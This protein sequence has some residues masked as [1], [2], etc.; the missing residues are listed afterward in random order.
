MARI[1]RSSGIEND[2]E[3]FD[4]EGDFGSQS[5]SSSS[6]LGQLA[7]DLLARW[8][9]LALGLVLGVLGAYYYLSKAPK[10]YNA[11]ATLSVVSKVPTL[12]SGLSDDGG[13][14]RSFEELN[15]L[16][17]SIKRPG[18]LG[19][20]ASNQDVLRAEGLVPVAADWRPEWSREW[21][22]GGDTPTVDP[23]KVSLGQLA[24]MIDSWTTVGI[25]PDTRLLD[26]RVTHPVPEV[27]SL[28]AN[29]I[30]TEFEKEIGSDRSA[31]R[32]SSSE[33]LRSESADAE[34][35]LQVKENAR[36]SYQVAMDSLAILEEKEALF[37]E[38]D[39]KYLEKHP[40]LIDAKASLDRI[41]KQFLSEFD[42]V[43]KSRT[44]E[45]YWHLNSE[46]LDS[47]YVD[48]ESRVQ[49]ARRLL[50]A[51]A[52]VLTS[53]I[54]SLRGV[55]N[56]LVKQLDQYDAIEGNGKTEVT[57]N[58]LSGVP[59][60]PSS[61]K[62]SSV[63]SGG[64]LTGLF[65]GLAFAFLLVRLDSKIH[66]VLQAEV[67]TNLPVLATI[68]KI[69]PKILNKIISE[70]VP[71]G[72]DGD[73]LVQKWDP[74]IVFRTG[75]SETV[76]A[77]MFRILRAS[78]TLLG[79]EKKRS[80]TLFTSAIPGEGKTLVSANFAIASAQQGKKTLLL[81]FDLRKPSLH[82]VF[83]LKRSELKSGLTELLA[84]QVT[85]QEALTGETGQENLS[86]IF[87]GA[88]APNPGELLSLEVVEN[89]LAVLKDEFEVI[90]VDSAPLL[91]VPDTRLVIPAVD[92]FCF[93]VQAEQTPKGAIKKAIALLN[94][95]G[96]EPAGVVVNGYEEKAGVFT[97]KYRYGYGYGGY[98]QYSEGYGKGSYGTYGSDQDD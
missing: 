39:L 11:T 58:S 84:G 74:R 68:R 37:Q 93:V 28:L 14:Y 34:E 23:G 19:S 8:Q 97:R 98:G 42:L 1:K 51:R 86:C 22:G 43:R 67:V 73:P 61:P 13:G 95:D 50:N 53:E 20:V 88:K 26:I 44:D 64:A 38:L 41:Q 66:T 81:D 56:L 54:E 80:V 75:L 10:V 92:N 91:A 89:L 46:E 62:E 21:L 3:E 69:D 31:G 70:K 27:A 79:D 96:I 47:P 60:S 7:F 76:Y 90:V 5:R 9:W 85:L 15:T 45:A 82:K 32:K 55:Y 83:G 72:V 12:V 18:L 52:T 57:V 49:I 16:V 33:I 29:T 30:A 2:I 48:Q 17:Q 87:S 94:D 78:V 63:I 71:E 40:K 36:A 65:S 6:Q 4:E 77:E 24:G 35:R 59:G 25:R